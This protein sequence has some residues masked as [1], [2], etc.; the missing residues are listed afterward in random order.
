MLN[1]ILG[2]N[3]CLRSPDYYDMKFNGEYLY[4][5]MPECKPGVYQSFLFADIRNYDAM[6]IWG[7]KYKAKLITEE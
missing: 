2:V 3:E 7:N 1:K 4:R 6:K 5:N